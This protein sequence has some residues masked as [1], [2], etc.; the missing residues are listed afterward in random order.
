M[1]FLLLETFEYFESLI[2]YF[3]IEDHLNLN[4]P[5][6]SSEEDLIVCYDQLHSLFN[7]TTE[8]FLTLQNHSI[9]QALANILGNPYLSFQCKKVSSKNNRKFKLSSESISLLSSNQRNKL[10]DFNLIINEQTFPTNF[11]LLCC[12]SEF[13]IQKKVLED[14]FIFF[15]PVR[16]FECFLQFLNI[17]HDEPF[18]FE[19]ESFSSWMLLI[20]T[21]SMPCLL[22]FIP[23][24]LLFPQNLQKAL[25]FLSKSFCQDFE[26]QFNQSISFLL[27]FF[28]QISLEQFLSLQSS[29]L[30]H[31]FSSNK[32]KII[33]EDFLLNLIM[34]MID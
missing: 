8:I 7:L 5:L 16:H 2:N 18:N 9:F 34:N 11:E 21:F 22:P 24:E 29:A 15:L 17:F 33:N 10:N 28:N 14:Q 27:Q 32:L 26:Q 31:L 3:V 20:D 4:Y 23:K 12:A 19:E 13:F 30:L 6:R 1:L 25:Y